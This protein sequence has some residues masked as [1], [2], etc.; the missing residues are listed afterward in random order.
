MPALTLERTTIPV[1]VPGNVNYYENLSGGD[2]TPAIISPNP[3]QIHDDQTWKVELQNFT[4]NGSIFGAFGAN[5]WYFRLIIEQLGGG[6]MSTFFQINFPVST[7]PFHVY[8]TQTINVPAG[9]LPSGLY[10]LYVSL[11]MR[12]ANGLTPIAGAGELT[13]SGINGKVLQV[14]NA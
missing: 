6:E 5:Q 13:P 3:P 8:P 12:D 2:Y 14:V 1:Y 10:K 4:Q 9:A 11:E 7:L